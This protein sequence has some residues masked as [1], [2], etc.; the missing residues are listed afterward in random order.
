MKNLHQIA[1]SLVEPGKG[2]LAADESFGT[3]EKRFTH[4]NLESTE[5]NRRAYREMLL[6]TPGIGQYISG[7][8]LFDETLRQ[9]T[10]SGQKFVEVLAQA[11]VMPGIK[12]DQGTAAMP[13]SPNEKITKGLG[14]LPARL[15]EY[16]KLGAAF[17]KWRAVIIIDNGLPTETNIRQNARDLAQ[18][19][20]D[21]QNA[22]LV[23]IVEPEVLM[24]GSHTLER[25]AEVS[26]QILIALFEE[27]DNA[28]VDI[29]GLILKTNMVIPGK[30]SGQTV[31]TEHIARATTDLFKEVLPTNLPGQ[32]FLSGGQTEVE[33][34]Q[35][36]N[37]INQ[38]GSFPWQLSFSYGRALQDSALQIWAGQVENVIKAQNQFL[39]RA[40]LNSLATLGKYTPDLEH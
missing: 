7:V 28:A 39:K 29:E 18:Y 36:L 30:K 4:I 34:T 3:I 25:C 37:A 6:T 33:A 8:I 11:G 20:K 17:T 10:A 2:I 38:Q 32:V 31:T 24:D 5:D 9:S 12:V 13:D 27:L 35:N 19:A 26:R 16:A 15:E 1:K 21:C 23:P 14:G 40:K 22:G